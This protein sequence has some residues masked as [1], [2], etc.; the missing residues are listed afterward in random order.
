MVV[1]V[2]F[3]VVAGA[4]TA[5]S[6]CVLP[7]LPAVLSAGASGGRRRPLGVV[8]GLAV[9]FTFAVVALAS[10]VMGV[11][12]AGDAARWAAI[13]VLAVSGIALLVPPLGDRLEAWASRLAGRLPTPRRG[14]RDGFWSGAL[15]GGALGFVY[16]PCAGPILAAVISVS[17]TGGTTLSVLVVALGYAAGSA[18]VLLLLALGGRRIAEALRRAGRGPAVTRTLGVIL[19]ATGVAMATRL[20][21]RAEEALADHA[22]S[23]LV[24]PTGGLER[25]H[26]VEARLARL[27]G[28]AKFADTSGGH[29]SPSHLPHLGV[30]PEF[31]KTGHW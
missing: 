2:L 1:L 5:V 18:V 6:P 25:S 15:L 20:D 28:P 3:A 17:A 7:V 21:V 14:G 22:P 24:N 29:A 12:V 16:A 9:T 27:R 13:V 23:F 30:A 11:G 31:R 10:V 4:G 19:L 26:A 8:L